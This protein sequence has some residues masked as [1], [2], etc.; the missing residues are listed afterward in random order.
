M[1]GCNT[2]QR[3]CFNQYHQ[4]VVLTVY[5]G[6]WRRKKQAR[7]SSQWKVPLCVPIF[8]TVMFSV[9]TLLGSLDMYRGSSNEPQLACGCDLCKVLTRLL[10]AAEEMSFVNLPA[11]TNKRHIH[12]IINTRNPAGG[13]IWQPDRIW[14]PSYVNWRR[15]RKICTFCL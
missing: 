6:N 13:Q 3:L 5:S 10:V 4:C 15:I 9:Q 2:P 14:S 12:T 8:L 1:W 11:T 7:T